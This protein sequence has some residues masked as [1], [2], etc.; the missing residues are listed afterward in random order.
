MD[1]EKLDSVMDQIRQVY[2]L[3]DD[4]EVTPES[5]L[6]EDLNTISM[7]YFAMMSILKD[8]FG[9]N[10]SYSQIKA[11]KTIQDVLDLGEE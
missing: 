5:T 2:S 11:C 7:H 9:K 4:R 1:K 10:V 8:E 3:R 6:V